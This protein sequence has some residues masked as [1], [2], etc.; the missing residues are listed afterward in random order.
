MDFQA[1]RIFKVSKKSNF[2]KFIEVFFSE[3]H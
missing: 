2:G 3:G 1:S